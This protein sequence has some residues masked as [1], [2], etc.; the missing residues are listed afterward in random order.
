M[1]VVCSRDHV[2][3]HP[4]SH[5]VSLFVLSSPYFRMRMRCSEL[6]SRS[7]CRSCHS[8]HRA[9]L[10]VLIFPVRL[11][12]QYCVLLML[13]GRVR[14]RRRSSLQ[15]EKRFWPRLWLPSL[16]DSAPTARCATVCLLLSLLCAGE[17]GY[18]FPGPAHRPRLPLQPAGEV[19]FA[20]PCQFPDLAGLC[21][22]IAAPVSACALSA[23]DTDGSL[24][25]CGFIRHR[26]C[27]LWEWVRN[28]G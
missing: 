22:A 17:P 28:S 23:H 25:L 8:P 20:C 11:C 18:R 16:N 1:N 19:P 26:C 2:A 6:A 13:Y 27:R 4:L 15:S 21:V 12:R 9:P 3:S 14:A 10:C 7:T 5:S 24:L